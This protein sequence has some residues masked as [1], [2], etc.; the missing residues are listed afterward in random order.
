MSL[1]SNHCH[2][3]FLLEN[4][5][6]SRL[7]TSVVVVN[8]CRG[9]RLSAD[10]RRVHILPHYQRWN[11]VFRTEIVH[12]P[13]QEWKG[14]RIIVFRYWKHGSRFRD[15]KQFPLLPRRGSSFSGFLITLCLV[16]GELL[17]TSK[18]GDVGKGR[19]QSC[20]WCT[21]MSNR[22]LWRWLSA[23]VLYWNL[24]TLSMLHICI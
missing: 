16:S 4:N 15:R 17:W 5:I 13:E 12:V 11:Y 20:S 23:R 1:P 3:E 6:S 21:V 2:V 24:I 22:W 14:Q 19:E 18:V 8:S 9:P 10:K 7:Y